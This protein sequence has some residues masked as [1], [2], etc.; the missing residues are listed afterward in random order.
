M[1]WV[2]WK[3]P[4]LPPIVYYCVEYYTN[5]I[6]RNSKNRIGENLTVRSLGSTMTAIPIAQFSDENICQQKLMWG[7]LMNITAEN[8]FNIYFIDKNTF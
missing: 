8:I 1:R 5:Y 3:T 4:S 2:A 7:G 6:I